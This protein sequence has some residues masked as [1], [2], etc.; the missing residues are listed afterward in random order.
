MPD[1]L[2]PANLDY[3]IE[4]Y[5]SGVP[6]SQIV[7]ECTISRPALTRRFKERGIK[8]RS[9]SEAEVLK[10]K[11]RKGD[12]AIVVK[13]LGRAWAARSRKGSTLSERRGRALTRYFLE[14]HVGRHEREMVTALRGVGFS[15]ST[16]HVVET[17]NVDIALA[18]Q[19][20]AVEVTTRNLTAGV[21]SSRTNRVED[22]LNRGW[23]VG[24]LVFEGR[25]FNRDVPGYSRLY[26]DY[27]LVAQHV[28]HI[29]DLIGRN[30][31][32]RRSYWVI[33]GDGKFR[34]TPCPNLEHIAFIPGA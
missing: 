24:F 2:I 9:Y 1:K 28:R 3:L 10:W 5:E 14:T 17:Y 20:I 33:R 32:P 11:L 4:K 15:P 31:A 25:R 7:K 16:Q 13:Q 34:T 27:R 22:L 23:S 30:E 18:E 19:G 12:R 8:I 26:A 21:G 6:M 29:V